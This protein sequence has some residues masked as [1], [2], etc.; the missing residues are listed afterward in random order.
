[1]NPLTIVLSTIAGTI[2]LATA[3]FFVWKLWSGL[4]SSLSAI[5]R[6]ASSIDK[7][8]QMEDNIK[9]IPALLEGQTKMCAA[10]IS[11]IG[12]LRKTVSDFKQAVFKRDNINSLE[13][14][15]DG[16]KNLAWEAQRIK[17]EN[18]GMDDLTAMMKAV[19]TEMK[20][21]NGASG[22]GEFSL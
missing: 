22:V 19:E 5:P 20:D 3:G 13:T 16:E 18:P 10:Q 21:L 9:T 4:L 8:I 7:Y 2:I 12:E 14:P 1:M 6:L 17:R 15:S 11:A